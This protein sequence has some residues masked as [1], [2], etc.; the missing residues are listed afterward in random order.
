MASTI[1]YKT[2]PVLFID[3]DGTL[4]NTKS[5]KTFPENAQD[6]ELKEG[7]LDALKVAKEKEGYIIAVVSNQGGVAHGHYE[8][9]DIENQFDTLHRLCE[10]LIDRD[11]MFYSPFH[12][13][14][15]VE[16][17]NNSSTLRKPDTGMAT[18]V[19]MYLLGRKN[20]KINWYG[21]KMVGDTKDDQDFAENTGLRYDYVDTF[22]LLNQPK[23]EV[24]DKPETDGK[25]QESPTVQS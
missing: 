3:R 21:S 11:M 14:G 22:I 16:P 13:Q 6:F 2:A 20:T 10:G 7:I 1:E 5:G 25:E 24:E 9:E 15:T 18:A 12:P 8:I 17:Y 19:E 4:V 23:K